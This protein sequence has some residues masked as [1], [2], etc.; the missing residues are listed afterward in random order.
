[1]RGGGAERVEG[2]RARGGEGPGREEDGGGEL[3]SRRLW[4]CE[5]W[6]WWADG[7]G[8]SGGAACSTVF[9]QMFHW[10]IHF[11]KDD[12][13]IVVLMVRNIDIKGRRQYKLKKGLA[14]R[15]SQHITRC[16]HK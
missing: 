9:P 13:I 8:G 6:S 11:V 16:Y 14:R 7:G 2:G 12:S 15:Q 5:V 1:V 4:G 3:S 10:L